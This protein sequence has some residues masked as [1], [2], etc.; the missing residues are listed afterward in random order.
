MKCLMLL[1]VMTAMANDETYCPPLLDV[2]RDR[3][4]VSLFNVADEA[5]GESQNQIVLPV[6]VR[7][8][9]LVQPKDNTLARDWNIFGRRGHRGDRLK[10]LCRRGRCG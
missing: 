7:L 2:Y 10:G 6:A 4:I 1:F 8:L 9:P 3:T 5:A